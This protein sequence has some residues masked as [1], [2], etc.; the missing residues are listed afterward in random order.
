MRWLCQILVVSIDMTPDTQFAL[1]TTQLQRWWCVVIPS[2]VQQHIQHNNTTAEVRQRRVNQELTMNI[3]DKG[4]QRLAQ[5]LILKWSLSDVNYCYIKRS[6]QHLSARHHFTTAV[7]SDPDKNVHRR[8]WENIEPPAWPGWSTAG[9]SS[10]ATAEVQRT[11]G[12]SF[13][14][15]ALNRSAVEHYNIQPH[16]GSQAA[17]K[18]GSQSRR[19]PLLGPSPGLEALYDLLEVTNI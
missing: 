8:V 6:F 15:W 4:R 17:S 14:A 10:V 2:T 7:L 13:T 19:R 16:P 11:F 5:T 1:C 9:P 3:I 12:F 18:G